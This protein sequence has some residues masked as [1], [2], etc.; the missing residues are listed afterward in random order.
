MIYGN[1]FFGNFPSKKICTTHKPA[2]GVH[3]PIMRPML[4]TL[5][6]MLTPQ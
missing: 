1:R 2:R 5:P 4:A 3:E 6:L